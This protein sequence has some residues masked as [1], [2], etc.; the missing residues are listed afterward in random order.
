LIVSEDESV[1]RP[2]ESENPLEYYYAM[3][4]RNSFGLAVDPIT[5]NL[6]DTENG[7]ISYDEINLVEPKF[8]SGW[9]KIMGPGSEEQKNTLPKFYGYKY[10]DPEFSWEQTVTPTAITFVN[11]NLFKEY[12]DYVLV[13]DFNTGT[14]YKFKLNEERTEFVFDEPTLKDLVLNI[15]DPRDEIIFATGYGGVSDLEFGPDGFLYVVSLGDGAIYKIKPISDFSSSFNFIIPHWFKNTA[16]WWHSD[17]ISNEDFLN[18]LQFLIKKEIIE[19]PKTFAVDKGSSEI[20]KWV[21]EDSGKWASDEIPDNEFG[22]IIQYLV[23]EK[24]VKLYFER[25]TQLQQPGADLSGCDFSGIELSGIKILD[26]IFS[27]N[28]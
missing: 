20:P 14:I 25:C 27:I 16:G 21:K 17:K 8:N 5:N 23:K 22:E 15:G 7:P 6:W 18:S 12:Q 28:L 26:C 10:S 1:L 13:G 4:I 2:S 9:A 11:S 3:G 24:L 19:I